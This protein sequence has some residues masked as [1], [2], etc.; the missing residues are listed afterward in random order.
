ASSRI[1][2]LSIL[3]PAVFGIGLVCAV[4]YLSQRN[5]LVRQCAAE[6]IAEQ[7]ERLR[8]TLASIGDAVL[9]TD[10]QGRITNMNAVAES[11]TG[12]TQAE[13]VGKSLNAVFNI[14]DEQTRASLENPAQ[15]ALEQGVIVGLANHAVLISKDGSERFIDDSAAPIRDAQGQLLGCVLVFRDIAQRRRMEQQQAEDK[16]RLESIVNHAIDGIAVI[17]ENG[18]VEAFNPAAEQMF[19]YEA[20]EVIGLNVKMLMPE[21][22][23]GEHDGYLANYLRT[24]Q[25]KIIGIGR[26]A[27]GR[28]KD[29]STFPLDLAVSEFRL[30]ERRYFTGLLRDIT[31]R[32]RTEKQVYDLLIE[33]KESDRRKDEFLAILA[34][35]LRGPLAP[36]RNMLE[37]MKHPHDGDLLAKARDTMERQLGQLVR[38]VD[39]LI[40]V[41]RITRDTIELRKERVELASLIHQSVEVCRPLADRAKQQ[42]SVSLPPQPIYLHG[43]SVRLAQVFSNIL[44]NACKYTEPCGKIALTAERQG[45]EVVVKVKDTGLGIPPDKLASVFEMFAQIDRTLERSQGGLGIGLTLVKRLIEMHDGTVTARSEGLGKG[46]EFIVRLP[47]LIEPLKHAA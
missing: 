45:S 17:D 29:G 18:T 22:F 38:L 11:L 47:I 13:A 2:I 31:D 34:H 21:P 23:H 35:E 40:D 20:E 12:W 24:G 44:N 8:V 19:G 16:A 41:S 36:L 14:V 7:R 26:E 32:K 15:R 5:L 33:L 37:I 10:T 28:R 4:F 3:L 9:T 43:D 1:T 30:G 39:D 46:S 6:A 25:R 42:V 27:D